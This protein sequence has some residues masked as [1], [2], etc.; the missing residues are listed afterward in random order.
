MPPQ[1]SVSTKDQQGK[2]FTNSMEY[3]YTFH[4]DTRKQRTDGISLFFISQK[5]QKLG[6][7][8]LMWG[9]RYISNLI[10]TNA[11]KVKCNECNKCWNCLNG[12]SGRWGRCCREGTRGQA[13][14]H[15][16]VE[17]PWF[18]GHLE[19]LSVN[20]VV[21]STQELFFSPEELHCLGI[22]VARVSCW[23]AGRVN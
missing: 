1:S 9:L 15:R 14:G 6:S 11:K 10:L 8:W 16:K 19:T 18:L 17:K 13:I 4:Y 22:E 23:E 12:C 7:Q 21:K 2:G 20:I 3:L 5:A